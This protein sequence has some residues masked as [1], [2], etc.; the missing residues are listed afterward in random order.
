[1]RYPDLILKGL[2]GPTFRHRLVVRPEAEVAG[3][4]ADSAL[5]SIIAQVT[6]PR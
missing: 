6:P 5:E 3:R 4:T 1:M 2:L